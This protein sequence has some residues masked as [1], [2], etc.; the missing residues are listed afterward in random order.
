MII[1]LLVINTG[2][3]VMFFLNKNHHNMHSRKKPADYIIQELNLNDEQ[4]KE[5][6]LL[7]K[8]HQTQM[9]LIQDSIRL[10]REKLPDAIIRGDDKA[11][12]SISSH[13]GKLQRQ[14]ELNTY[15]HFI[16]VKS[17]C[18]DQQKNKFNTIISDILKM[19][20]GKDH[21]PPMDKH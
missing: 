3:L 13:I 12:D 8:E 6:H 7:K 21:P 5:F 1:I 9:K 4:T 15:H 2:T 11:A 14:I 17:I 16:K 19:M 18:D 20:G 10:E